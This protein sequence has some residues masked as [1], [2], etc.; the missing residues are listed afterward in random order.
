[1]KY[2][3]SY[4]NSQ[5]LRIAQEEGARRLLYTYNLTIDEVF[6]KINDKPE[7]DVMLD[8]GAFTVW[9]TA[10]REGRA[11]EKIDVEAYKDFCLSC[12][13]HWFFVN[14]DVI[15]KTGS[16]PAEIQKCIDEGYENY[17]YLNEHLPNVLPVYHYGEDIKV[18]KR[19]EEHTD[20]VA[21]S[22][23]NDTSEKVKRRF[24]TMIYSQWDRN[25]VV[26]RT[27]YHALG[28]SSKKGLLDFPLFSCDSIS[29]KR[30]QLGVNG[31]KRPL[32]YNTNL[33][34]IQRHKVREFLK[35]EKF[36]T[37]VWRDRGVIYD[38]RS[39]GEAAPY[40][41]INSG[42]APAERL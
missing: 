34:I 29:Y 27:K 26:G 8:S 20:Y 10:R 32:L 35:L 19:F 14:V 36:V 41:E 1:M 2:Y 16:T 13:P 12:P 15:P 7:L 4:A 33:N 31:K 23:A 38:D 37:H 6:K 24:L 28:Y 9:Q 39:P 17:L 11:D 5:I 25:R 40:P 18:L 42:Q 21:I 22:P 3:F 30:L